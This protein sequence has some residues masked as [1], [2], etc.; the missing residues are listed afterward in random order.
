L[1]FLLFYSIPTLN[2]LYANAII[3]FQ[4]VEKMNYADGYILLPF[5]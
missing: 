2:R 3:A 5:I 4:T 1:D